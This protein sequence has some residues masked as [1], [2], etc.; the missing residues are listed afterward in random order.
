MIKNTGNDIVDAMSRLNISGLVIPHS[1][2]KTVTMESG[3]LDIK[4]IILLSDIVGWYQLSESYEDLL[5]ISYSQIERK[6]GFTKKEARRALQTL[7]RLDVVHKGFR[8]ENVRGRLCNNI[9][10]LTLN[11]EALERLTCLDAG[12]GLNA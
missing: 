7:E 9:M 11:V 6:L 3:K 12:G 4:A 8:T 10:Y 2:L 1:W 5:Q